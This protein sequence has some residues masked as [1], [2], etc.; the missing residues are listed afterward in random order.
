[1]TKIK[2]QNL[3]HTS[4]NGKKTMCGLSNQYNTADNI[5]KFIE[6]LHDESWVKWCCKKCESAI[7]HT[8]A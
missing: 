4:Q 7:K 8:G 6:R 2:N 3:F 1:M 5:Q